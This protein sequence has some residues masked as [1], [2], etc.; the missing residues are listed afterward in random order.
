MDK[1]VKKESDFNICFQVAAT[2]FGCAIGPALVAGTYATLYY[3]KYGAWG[4]IMPSVTALIVAVF[5]YLGVDMVRSFKSYDYDLYATALYGKYKKP[6]MPFFELRTL[7]GMFLGNTILLSMGGNMLKQLFG[8]NYFLGVA[9]TVAIIILLSMWGARVLRLANTFMSTLLLIA[10]LILAIIAIPNGQNSLGHMITKWVV[11]EDPSLGFTAA[12]WAAMVY[13][14]NVAVGHISTVGVMDVIT[15]RKQVVLTTVLS[16]IMYA[17]FM[18]L[19]ALITLP[20]YP[21]VVKESLPNLW[22]IEN[23]FQQYRW[24]LF[25]M[26][27][28]I[29]FLG[30]FTTGPTLTFAANR[31]FGKLIPDKVTKNQRVKFFTIGLIFNLICLAI[32]GF[33]LMALIGKGIKILG[34]LSFPFIIL[35]L[36]LFSPKRVKENDAK[37]EVQP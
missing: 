23:F 32:S 3:V 17:L 7:F 30:L 31:R 15:K 8:F 35:P 36:A 33:G 2:W 28:I 14:F 16:F 34:Y 24:W 12:F 22:I 37:N 1:S 26:Y 19:T 9:I 20:Y 27:N 5:M 4:V 11:P 29:I 13:G 10:V 6:M 25:P 21:E 18:T